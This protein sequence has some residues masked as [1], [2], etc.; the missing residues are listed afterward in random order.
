MVEQAFYRSSDPDIESF[1]E[2]M[3]GA[4][5]RRYAFGRS[6]DHARE[7]EMP[8]FLSDPESEPDPSEFENPLTQ[9]RASLSLRILIGVSAAAVIAILFALVTSDATR[10]V[11]LSAK[12]SLATVLPTSAAAEPENTQLT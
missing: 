2:D 3:I 11:L 7:D 8:L 10:D 9:R 6:A 12:A 5:A 1:E 4:P